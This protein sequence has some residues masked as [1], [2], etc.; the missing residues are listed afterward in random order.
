[1]T[2]TCN[3]DLILYFMVVTVI[4]LC[5]EEIVHIG[6][7]NLNDFSLCW[8]AIQRRSRKLLGVLQLLCYARVKYTSCTV[9]M[10]SRASL[11]CG[12]N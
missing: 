7:Q 8:E 9:T 4:R 2:K 6:L 1:M 12:L 3:Q 10:R 5:D 11:S